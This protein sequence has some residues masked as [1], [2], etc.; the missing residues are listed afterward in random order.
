MTKDEWLAKRKQGIGGTDISALMGVNPYA[1]AID[2]F[3]DKTT[4]TTHDVDSMP[5][6]RGRYLEPFVAEL[7]AE[8]TDS[9]LFPN[10]YDIYSHPLEDFML[11]TPDYLYSNFIHE[12]DILE[13]KTA[14]GVGAKKWYD[15]IPEYVGLQLQQQMYVMGKNSITLATLI[16]DNFNYIEIQRNDDIIAQMVLVATD[17][18]YNNVLANKI[19]EPSTIE[20]YKKVY[21][22][23]TLGS[24]VDASNEILESFIELQNYKKLL[25]MQDAITKQ[26]KE[27]I[28]K[29]DGIIRSYMRDYETLIYTDAAGTEHVLATYRNNAKGSRT[30]SLKKFKI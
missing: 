2:V 19:P 28:E 5:K 12:K 9:T 11:A 18:W 10:G 21:K 17:F 25:S 30:L 14:V 7:F 26:T 22:V 20:D 27:R 3:F 24:F 29:Y 6:R 15:G 1:T 16:D 23:A 13:I 8:A 4:E